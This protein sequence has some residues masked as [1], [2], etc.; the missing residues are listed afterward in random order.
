M[1]YRRMT[2]TSVWLCICGLILAGCQTTSL[3]M[4]EHLWNEDSTRRVVLMPMDIELSLLNAGG[5]TEP[6]AAW[7]ETAKK[8]ALS[9]LEEKLGETSAKLVS[10]KEVTT[11]PESVDVQLVKLHRA[12][13]GTVLVHKYIP[14][15]SLPT[16]S[17]TFDWSL[18]PDVVSIGER[19]DADYALFV[20]VRDSYTSGGRAAVILLAAVLGAGVQGGTQVGFA[21]LVDL[22][23]GEV[24]WFNRLAR[25][26]GDMRHEKGAKDTVGALLANFPK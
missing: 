15:L 3:G 4:R 20:F 18:G 24:V 14:V 11:D 6:N 10:F 9:A 26:S 16:K 22:K 5:V 1:N 19:H 17:E 7:T 2:K 12:V 21:S 25:G 13:G 23:S 8:L